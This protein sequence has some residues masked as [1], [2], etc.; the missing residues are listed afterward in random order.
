MIEVTNLNPTQFVG[1]L[2]FAAAAAA[3]AWAARATRLR[4]WWKLAW[5][6]GAA[7]LEA[8][9]GLRHRLHGLVDG[10]LQAQG[11]YE[12]RGPVQLGLIVLALLVF[13]GV[14]V[15]L[16]RLRGV[17]GPAWWAAVGC[18]A[19]WGLFL[20]ETISLHGVDSLMYA[21]IGQVRVIGWAWVVIALG[22]TGAG[23]QAAMAGRKSP[24]TI[25]R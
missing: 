25:R 3:C 12:S 23:M 20:I 21:S 16:W 13:G 2:G 22:V 11:W 14:L 18:A 19:A 15:W 4:L 10:A 9:F 17:S 8:V 6:C 24:S 7:A 1:L 5:A